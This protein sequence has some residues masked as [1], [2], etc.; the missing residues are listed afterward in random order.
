MDIGLFMGFDNPPRW[1]QLTSEV[2]R[3]G[4]DDVVLAEELGFDSVWLSEHHF[5][6]D[7]WSP[8]P[9]ALAA[10][11]ATR[12][13]RIRI[14]TF[15]VIL[16]LHHPL[17]VAEDAAT[18]DLLSGGRLDLGVGQGYRPEEFA[19]FGVSRDTRPGRLEEGVEIIRR[20]WTGERFSYRGQHYELRDVRLAPR[21]VQQ[22]HPP[23]W[24][25]ARGRKAL[26][27]VAR[28]G[29]H[30]VGTGKAETAQIYDESLRS[31]GRD[32]ADHHV[33]QILPAVYVAETRE[34]AWDTVGEHVHHLLTTVIAHAKAGADL[35]EDRALPAP[36]AVDD[37]RR[38]DPADLPVGSPVV[39]TPEDCVRTLRRHCEASKVTHLALGM[40]LPGVPAKTTRQSIELFAREVLPHLRSAAQ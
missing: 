8:S 6:A 30:L 5:D 7:S 37:L 34:Q 39:G 2:Y 17:Q 1:P 25:G 29:C 11:I 38:L 15:I 22:P 9:L 4:L 35:A 16:P 24:I 32:P 12:T 27:R 26:D 13:Q 28:L 40:H 31:H 21:P 33:A 20:A 19:G 14:G 3:N 10:A 23:L 36:P 18:V